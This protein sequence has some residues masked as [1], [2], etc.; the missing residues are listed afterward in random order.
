MT[1]DWNAAR[2]RYLSDPMSVRLG[3]LASTLT[4]LASATQRT[5]Q[6]LIVVQL[7]R[8]CI[9]FIEWNGLQ[10]GASLPASLVPLQVEL[11]RWSRRLS[12][13]PNLELGPLA[14]YASEQA[15]QALQMAG[16]L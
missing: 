14:R 13:Q 1:R 6:R 16:Y 12:L 11:A 8:E 2:Q 3:N 7:L 15:Q 4:R 10:A 9:Y 5:S